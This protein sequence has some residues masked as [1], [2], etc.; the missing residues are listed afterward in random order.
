MIIFIYIYIFTVIR[1]LGE[2]Y[3]GYASFYQWQMGTYQCL[4]GVAVYIAKPYSYNPL[5]FIS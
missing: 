3:V 1:I 2:K 4:K 5:P